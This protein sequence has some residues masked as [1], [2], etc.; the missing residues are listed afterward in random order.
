[1]SSFQTADDAEL[2][3]EAYLQWIGKLPREFRVAQILHHKEVL[4]VPLKFK[5]H[6]SDENRDEKTQADRRGVS[7]F[8]VNSDVGE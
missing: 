3:L 4:T 7:V 8:A 6:S 1:V 2:H 5:R